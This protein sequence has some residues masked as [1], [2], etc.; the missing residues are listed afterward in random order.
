MYLDGYVNAIYGFV[1]TAVW[2]FVSHELQRLTDLLQLGTAQASFNT[3]CGR[4]ASW[5]KDVA[6]KLNAFEGAGGLM[7]ANRKMQMRRRLTGRTTALH[8]LLRIV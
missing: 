3:S 5:S 1:G 2:L 7:R 4:F 8:Q 6:A